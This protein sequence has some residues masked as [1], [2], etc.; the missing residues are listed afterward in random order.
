[1]KSSF[2]PPPTQLPTHLSQKQ[3]EHNRKMLD[4][5]IIPPTKSY[6]L[7]QSSTPQTILFAP[8]RPCRKNIL[9]MNWYPHAISSPSPPSLSHPYWHTF[10]YASLYQYESLNQSFSLSSHSIEQIQK[11]SKYSSLSQEPPEL[12]NIAAIFP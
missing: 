10:L 6:H 8:V 7:L 5:G 1:M 4:E 12:S 11:T 3:Y 2:S 9:P